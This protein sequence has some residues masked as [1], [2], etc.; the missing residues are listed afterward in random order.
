MPRRRDNLERSVVDRGNDICS[1]MRDSGNAPAEISF[2]P[3]DGGLER[4]QFVRH[5]LGTT[6]LSV[7]QIELMRYLLSQ[8]FMA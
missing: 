6:R 8:D 1:R 2:D 7:F 3:L 5:G 4:T